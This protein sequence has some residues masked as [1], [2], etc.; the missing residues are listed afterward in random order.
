MT[1]LFAG[2]KRV[3]LVYKLLEDASVCKYKGIITQ[4]FH[5]E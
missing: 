1:L 2:R 5:N 3:F 4:I